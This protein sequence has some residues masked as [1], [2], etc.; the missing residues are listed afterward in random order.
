MTKYRCVI[1]GCGKVGMEYAF[2]ES[3][4]KPRSHFESLANRN[5]VDLVAVADDDS[6]K[7]K[8]AKLHKPDIQLFDDAEECLKTVKPDIV[9]I[10]TPT[11][12]HKKIIDLACDNNAKA[13]LSEKPICANIQD[14]EKI[15]QKLK[16]SGT[17][18]VLNYQRRYWE[19]FQ[20]A[21]KAIANGKIGKI[22]QVSCYYTNGL[23]NN[24]GHLVDSTMFL[25][26]I[27]PVSAFGVENSKNKI[28]PSGDINIDGFIEFQDGIRTSFQSMDI[29]SYGIHEL[30]IFGTSGALYV[31]RH[32]YSF[33][34][35]KTKIVSGIPF[36][37][38]GEKWQKEES[39]VG[40][41][42]D[43]VIEVC[44]GK[45]N[46]ISGIDNGIEVI[47]AVDA[48]V[49]SAKLNGKITKI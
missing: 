45:Q 47:K 48:L 49:K 44:E 29:N 15:K 37:K 9:I 25:L 46:P 19:L 14:A 34:W 43:N 8:K 10:A 41:A 27:K 28:K 1:I 12:T 30:R 26:G 11:S 40:G 36:F 3:R 20:K 31:A 2:D 4:I 33:E 38:Q 16:N 22:Q 23:Y 5:D 21:R 42:L 32:G 6:A 18:L 39:F 17:L 24:A 13:I 7:L 35:L